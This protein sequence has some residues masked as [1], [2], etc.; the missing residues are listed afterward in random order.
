MKW[1]VQLGSWKIRDFFPRKALLNCGPASPGGVVNAKYVNWLKSAG[2]YP[3]KAIKFKRD[4]S[5]VQKPLGSRL[6]Y[7]GRIP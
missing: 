4:I 6:Q 1:N 7:A 5:S 2:E 3:S